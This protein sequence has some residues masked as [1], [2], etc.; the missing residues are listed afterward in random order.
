MTDAEMIKQPLVSIVTNTLNRADL[1][2]R[3]IESIQRQTYQ[4]YEHIIVDGNSQDNTEEVVK[5]YR[6]PHI[7]YIKLDRKG[8]GIQLRAG[9]EAAIGKYITFLDDDDE[10][11]PDKLEKQVE[12]FETLEEDYG[13]VY[14]WMSYFRNNA[15][16][17][18]IRI[19]KPAFTGDVS[20][21][22]P[23]RPL[24]CG[25]P[26][27]MVRRDVFEKY[28]ISFN[29]NIG[30]LG[31]DWELMARI[32]QHCLVS[33]VPKSLVKVYVNHGHTRL[34]TD[35][36]SDKARRGIIFHNH[37]LKEFEDVFQR[38]PDS[39][40]YHYASLAI[41][42]HKLKE[43]ASCLKYYRMFLSCH[44]NVKDFVKMTLRII[45]KH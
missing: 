25:T 30:Q 7:K 5:G 34:T 16:D 8:P 27:M 38:H 41:C 6:D 22:A 29:D 20:D 14:C 40:W 3:C 35:T 10:Y 43:D 24:I 31:S 9:A 42:Y 23:T 17:K 15:P 32:C 12:L 33:Y 37:F 19:H 28:G 2:H 1:I 21:L 26:T 4:N 36:L 44:P 45:L 18:V 13:V 39:A 11:L